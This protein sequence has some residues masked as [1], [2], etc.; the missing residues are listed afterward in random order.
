MTYR[1]YKKGDVV[2][3]KNP[4]HIR[5]GENHGVGI[6]IGYRK[7]LNGKDCKD[8]PMVAWSGDI[9]HNPAAA[10]WS[11]LKPHDDNTPSADTAQWKRCVGHW[12][13]WEGA[14]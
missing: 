4:H 14:R 13:T 10:L 1:L 7:L 8:T 6:V 12:M 11:N 9:E 2:R 3:L 5:N